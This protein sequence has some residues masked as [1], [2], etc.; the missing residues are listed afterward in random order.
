MRHQQR[1]LCLAWRRAFGVGSFFHDRRGSTVVSE[2]SC[3]DFVG[4][5]A[6]EAM[7]YGP[8]QGFTNRLVVLR[9]NPITRMALPEALQ[10]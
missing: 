10:G 8:D 9:L 5:L 6:P 3:P 4:A 7:L 1:P 2:P